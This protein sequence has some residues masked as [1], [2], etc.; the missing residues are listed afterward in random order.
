MK[1]ESGRSL[2]SLN[3]KWLVMLASLDVLAVILFIAPELV[4][5]ASWSR[6][7]VLRGAVTVL[8]PVVV[9]LLTGLLSHDAK[10]MLVF[11]RFAN[12]LPGS[13]AFIEYA[14]S[15]ARIDMAALR[16]NVGDLPSDAREQNQKWFR[17]YRVV[18]DELTVAEAHRMYLLYRDMAAMSLPLIV[19]IPMGLL[20]V[21][22]S[23]VSLALSAV[24]FAV[25]Y[26]V[27]CLG[28]QNSGKRFVCNVL[29]I[30]ATKRVAA[31]K[32]DAA[33]VR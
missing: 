10:A 6:L 27:C 17:L 5:S 1:Q 14:P 30:H 16:R 2:K 3:M 21:G 33:K 28:A 29:A 20:I 13:R 18:G 25:Q 26:L 4:E 23:L 11:W 24:L 31:A 15:D 9:L 8:L 19:L 22:S 7:A 12:P 32:V